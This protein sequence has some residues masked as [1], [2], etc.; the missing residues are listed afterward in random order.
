LSNLIVS[1]KLGDQVSLLPILSDFTRKAF[2]RTGFLKQI[3]LLVPVPMHYLSQFQRGFNQS[4]LIAKSLNLP[5]VR[6]NSELVRVRNTQSQTTVTFAQRPKN[7]LNAFAV[8][9]NHHFEGKNICLIDDV[10]T[11]G[12]TLNEC[13]KT[14]REAGAG[15]VFA[16]VLAVA[17]QGK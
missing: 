6:I 15:K 16:F 8:R 13:A 14:L 9:K 10:K 4:Y 11:S 17:G 1:F 7:V 3:D 5:D 2:A 12:A